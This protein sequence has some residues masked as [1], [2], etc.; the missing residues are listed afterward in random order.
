VVPALL[1]VWLAG[2]GGAVRQVSIAAGNVVEAELTVGTGS[3][4]D[5]EVLGV[6]GGVIMHPGFKTSVELM[7]LLMALVVAVLVAR[8]VIGNLLGAAAVSSTPS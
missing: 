3:L 6:V 8:Q 7:H 2:I 1:A 5:S 4:I